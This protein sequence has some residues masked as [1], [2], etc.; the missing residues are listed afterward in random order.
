MKPRVVFLSKRFLHPLDTGGKIRTARLLEQLRERWRITLI[1]HYDPEY[2]A[3]G[4]AYVE[5]LGERF[6]AVP[7]PRPTPGSLTRRLGRLLD[8]RPLA[9]IYDTDPALRAAIA[10]ELQVGA[11]LFVCDFVQSSGNVPWPLPCASLLFTH[12]VEARILR[13]QAQV[14]RGPQR[15]FWA[16]QHRRMRTFE[17]AECGR[18]DRVVAVSDSDREEFERDYDL[19]GRVRTIP[20]GVDVADVA[21]VEPESDLI[22]FCGSMDYVPNRDGIEWFATEVLP[23]LRQKRPGA[24]L[25]VVGRRPPEAF[26][27][28]HASAQIEFTGWVEDVRPHLQRASAV[29]VPLRVGGG[30]RIKIYEA[31]ALRLPVVSTGVGAEG[32]PLVPGEHYLRADDAEAFAGAVARTLSDAVSARAMAACAREY[33]VSRFGWPHVADVFAGVGDEAMAAFRAARG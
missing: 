1:G 2:D 18:Y 9:A 24:R 21:A 15:A 11:D 19:V 7:K 31:M 8:R 29:I 22:A 25:L 27:S 26:V 10:A 6:V 23:P 30:T 5:S 32:L 3:P 17:Q 33:V 20:T 28:R 12:N 14:Q 13:R 16:L 4:R